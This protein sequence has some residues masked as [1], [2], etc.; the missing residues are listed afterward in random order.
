[1]T[2]VPARSLDFRKLPREMK[3]SCD[4]SSVVKQK[5]FI[6]FIQFQGVETPHATFSPR[7]LKDVSVFLFTPSNTYLYGIPTNTFPNIRQ[8]TLT[9]QYDS[10]TAQ[11]NDQT[12]V[13]CRITS[14]FV[15]T[16]IVYGSNNASYQVDEHISSQS[17]GYFGHSLTNNPNWLSNQGTTPFLPFA[18]TSSSGTFN[19]TY[20][21]TLIALIN[22]YGENMNRTIV[23]EILQDNSDV[24]FIRRTQNTT[25]GSYS[26]PGSS[27][28]VSGITKIEITID[29]DDAY[30]QSGYALSNTNMIPISVQS[31]NK[32]LDYWNPVLEQDGY[33]FTIDTD[34]VVW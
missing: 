5:P 10:F 30:L 13:Y 9:G 4:S 6:D 21:T 26:Y 27:V 3:I 11:W 24:N 33:K 16:G 12:N 22:K 18:Y 7:N 14:N 32:I 1:M 23:R 28:T 19:F 34:S 15:A 8:R 29:P 31:K 25:I 2:V 20:L 17:L